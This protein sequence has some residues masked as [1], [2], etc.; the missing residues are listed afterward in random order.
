M[1]CAARTPSADEASRLVNFYTAQRA[2]FARDVEA[3]K[4]VAGNTGSDRSLLAERAAW[5]MTANVLLNLDET[6]TKE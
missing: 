6:L 1:I 3:A 4:N 5:T 2:R